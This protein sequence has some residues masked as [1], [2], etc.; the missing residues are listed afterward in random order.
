MKKIITLFEN[1]AFLMLLI[2]AGVFDSNVVVATVLCLI[3]AFS[4]LFLTKNECIEER[5][6]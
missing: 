5:G 3:G 2:G 4:L 6:L 1:I